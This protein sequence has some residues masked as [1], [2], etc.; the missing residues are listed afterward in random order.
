[1]QTPPTCYTII[2]IIQNKSNK[3][4][5]KNS[6]RQTKV[7]VEMYTIIG[8]KVT[9]K[10]IFVSR[11]LFLTSINII[12]LLKIMTLKKI[13]RI[14]LSLSINCFLHHYSKSPECKN[15]SIQH[16]IKLCSCAFFMF[17]CNHFPA[18]MIL[19]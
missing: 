10:H 3:T 19:F 16:F 9:I 5:L 8:L 11:E 1:M 4:Y 2:D 6:K 14:S 13:F 17:G 18:K 12:L 15:D 7:E